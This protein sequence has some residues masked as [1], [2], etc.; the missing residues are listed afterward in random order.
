ME[1]VKK[2]WIPEAGRLP[3]CIL[4]NGRLLC[5]SLIDQMSWKKQLKHKAIPLEHLIDGW[6]ESISVGLQA[7]V[8][9]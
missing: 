1:N 2:Y 8:E 6:R 4:V 3:L 9:I 5:L 7:N